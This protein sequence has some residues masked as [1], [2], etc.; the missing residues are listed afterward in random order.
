[1]ERISPA[2]VQMHWE[3][4]S[5]SGEP[6]M[7]ST[8]TLGQMGALFHDRDA[9]AKLDPTTPLYSV[10]WWAPVPAGTVGGLYWGVTRIE[11]GCVGDEFYMTHGHFHADATRAEFYATAQGEGMLVRMDRDRKTWAE[12]MAPGSLHAIDGRHAHRVVNTGSAPLIFWAAW[13][14]DAGYDY[15]AIEREGFGGRV[16]RRDGK[17]VFEAC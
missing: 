13:G 1:M 9:V 3:T 15:A 5:M 2:A 7:R 16:L 17:A 8:K 12:V 10:A 4:G 11:P 14:S 6:V